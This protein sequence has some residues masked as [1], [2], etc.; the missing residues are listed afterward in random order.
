MGRIDYGLEMLDQIER[1]ASIYLKIT[2]SFFAKCTAEPTLLCT[3][4]DGEE[5]ST[6]KKKTLNIRRTKDQWQG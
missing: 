6:H 1:Y 2:F 4:E 5:E 3:F